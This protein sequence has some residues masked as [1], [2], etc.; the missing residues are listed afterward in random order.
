[1]NY[2]DIWGQR[3]HLCSAGS[4]CCPGMK[5][6]SKLVRVDEN[7]LDEI[8][9]LESFTPLFRL[10]LKKGV[11]NWGMSHLL[12]NKHLHSSDSRAKLSW[13]SVLFRAAQLL[14]LSLLT[15]PLPPCPKRHIHPSTADS[16]WPG[17][18][19][20]LKVQRFESLLDLRVRRVRGIP[21][22]I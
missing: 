17:M 19:E 2:Q 10:T 9:S 7:V 12:L 5:C 3:L 18:W 1:M 20:E 11:I 14:L 15:D 4:L 21:A 6:C 13:S 22:L 8:N 16:T